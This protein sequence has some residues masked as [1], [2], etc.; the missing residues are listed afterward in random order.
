MTSP[1]GAVR[2]R[3]EILTARRVPDVV[4]RRWHQLAVAAGNPF[5]L[6]DWHAAWIGTHPADEPLVLLCRDPAREIRGVVPFVMRDRRL[7]AA[8][9]QLAD[10]FG[11]A[12]APAD[13]ER[14]AAAVVDALAVAARSWSVCHLDRCK[15]H[16]AWTDA[17][18]RA[19]GLS[20]VKVF[21]DRGDDSLVVVDLVRDGPELATSKKRREVERLGRR[22]REA[23]EVALR[24]S[25]TPAQID[26]DLEVLLRLRTAQWGA[27][28]D[29]SAEAF[30]RSFAALLAGRGLLRLWAIQVD[31]AT[32]GVLLGWRLGTRAFAY[33]HAFDRQYERF[34]IG[35]ALLA[36][37]VR[38]S[39]DEGCT[40]FDML[41]GDEHFKGSFHISSEAVTS[42]RAV[43]R[44][45][46]TR[47]HI[48]VLCR[49]RLAYDHLPPS[50]RRQL[51]RVVQLARRA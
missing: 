21:P 41:R 5:V 35:M 17:L 33:S 34:G 38:A 16:S 27:G 49:A 20:R 40:H 4:V 31:G 22:L 18:T 25:T 46:L 30:V 43:R 9:E 50:K 19:T 37:A 1:V 15:P 2:L 28:F 45:S 11:P 39:A 7:L 6:P 10:W 47:L 12:C 23:H 51:R 14:V 44:R 8:G 36:H 29:Q 42:Y 48:E 32:V 3:A 24:L 13:E 26:H